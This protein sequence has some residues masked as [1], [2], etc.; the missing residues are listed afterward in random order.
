M[1]QTVNNWWPEV[2]LVLL[3]QLFFKFEIVYKWNIKEHYQQIYYTN[4]KLI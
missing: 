2:K 4:A 1:Q 3:F